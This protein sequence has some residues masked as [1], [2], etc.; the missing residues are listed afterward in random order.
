MTTHG[1]AAKSARQRKEAHPE[2]YCPVGRCLWRTGGDRC[3]KHPAPLAV[4]LAE[5]EARDP[6]LKALGERIENFGRA[7]ATADP[8]KSYK[9]TYR[10]VKHAAHYGDATK[11]NGGGHDLDEWDIAAE[12]LNQAKALVLL[13]GAEFHHGYVDKDGAQ[14][15]VFSRLAPF[16][17]ERCERCPGRDG[18]G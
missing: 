2:L 4:E 17:A 5:M 7:I 12:S 14:R 18:S 6:K 11:K 9:V 3:P 13:Q 1:S 15:W 8:S 16:S 10:L